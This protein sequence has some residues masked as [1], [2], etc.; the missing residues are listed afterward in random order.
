M[1]VFIALT[2][3]TRTMDNLQRTASQLQPFITGGTLVPKQNYHLTLHFLGE[4]SESDLIFVQAA[5]D[6]VKDMLAPTLAM[7]RLTVM[8][9]SNAVC[10]KLSPNK[11]LTD[12][13]EALGSRLEQR[14]FTVEHRA[15]RPHVTLLRKGSFSLPIGEVSKNVKIYNMPFECGKVTLYQ[16]RLTENGAIYTEL[17]SVQLQCLD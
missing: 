9:P 7:H 14:G 15:F 11:L 17:Y 3:P 8:R 16:S 6:E 10:V 1:R 5:M 2:L 4:V 12:L 13:H